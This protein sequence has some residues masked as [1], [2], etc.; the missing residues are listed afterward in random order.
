MRNQRNKRVRIT[1]KIDR[2]SELPDS[3]LSHILS[4]LCTK[5]AIRTSV[6]SKRWRLVW[7]SLP[8][9]DFQYGP[10]KPQHSSHSFTAFVNHVLTLRD[11][12]Q[13]NTFRF[14]AHLDV[15]P[16]LVEECISYAVCHNVQELKIRAFCSRR[17]VEIAPEFLTCQSLRVLKLTCASSMS[18]VLPKTL[19][20]PN[21]RTLHLKH[22]MF[23]EKNFNGEIFSSCL[24][25]ETLVLCK[26]MI[27]PRDKLMIL[28]IS[29]LQLKNLEILYWR[30]PWLYNYEQAIF[31]ATPK[32]T[33]IRIE[34]H[35]SPV[36]FKEELTCL[37][38]VYID[39]CCPSS[40][41]TID[42]K[43]RKR[44]T[45]EN[46]MSMLGDLSHVRSLTL[47]LK[48]IEIFSSIPNLREREF[49][50]L[51]NLTFLRFKTEHKC[52]EI[53]I[54]INIM[55]Y[56]LKSSGS[57][58]TLV[59]D[60]P[61][62]LSTTPHLKEQKLSTLGDLKHIKLKAGRKGMNVTIPV[63]VMTYLLGSSPCVENLVV[64][65]PEVVSCTFFKKKLV[66][67]QNLK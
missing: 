60:L 62:I 59:V 66:L 12:S 63:N 51:R 42:L 27:K 56:L 16:N 4:F 58:K 44:K 36:C 48:T 13:I 22:F 1:D 7:A 43:D 38:R 47:S 53:T 9:L 52:T 64:E 65:F 29:A 6:L 32:L 57:A 54:P 14:S 41:A 34:G 31:V 39:L 55:V 8:N 40:C 24:S 28:N 35:I 26:C 25:L 5:T 20:L 46:L 49:Y 37:N 21:L 10:G 18:L 3:I 30:C 19:G 11:N 50:T 61:K 15:D 23:S 67:K 17:P 45:A 33:S 2:F